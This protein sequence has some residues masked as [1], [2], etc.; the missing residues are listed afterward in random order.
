M[1]G[2]LRKKFG[3][4][5]VNFGF[6]FNEGSFRAIETGKGLHEFTVGPLAEGSFDRTMASAGIPLF[7][8]DLRQLPKRGPVADWFSKAHKMRSIGAIYSEKDAES[9]MAIAEERWQDDYDAVFF[10]NKTAASRGNP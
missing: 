6:S 4:D 7:A 1:G 2:Y 8:L 10:V 5:L 9:P 3:R